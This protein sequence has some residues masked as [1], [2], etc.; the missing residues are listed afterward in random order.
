MSLKEF[1]SRS[2]QAPNWRTTIELVREILSIEKRV[3]IVEPLVPYKLFAASI[4]SP[5][6]FSETS[7]LLDIGRTYT[8]VD[9]KLNVVTSGSISDSGSGYTTA[10]GVA[11]TGGTGTGLT[12]NTTAV[13]GEITAIVIAAPGENY[14]VG[15]EV[16]ITGGGND[17]KILIT[18][19]ASD[20]FTIVGA[21]SN[22]DAVQF[23]ATGTTPVWANGS[24]LTATTN[25]YFNEV[26]ANTIHADTPILTALG[27][28]DF[29]ILF[30]DN[31]F[32]AG[33]VDLDFKTYSAPVP[34]GPLDSTTAWIRI[35]NTKT[36][37]VTLT[38]NMG[39]PLDGLA[40]K[41]FLKIVVY[42]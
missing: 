23:V 16:T 20:D 6:E 18:G 13:A 2:P 1:L 33:K 42:N 17:A 4:S 7:G 24:T 14:S 22:A 15:D 26:L 37:Q 40:Y 3:D 39:D 30:P 38:D 21:L 41:A 12:V 29:S 5:E 34:S 32:Y 8:I 10:A 36:I 19:I 28:A 31:I 35:M 11:T 27:T 25:P 9:I